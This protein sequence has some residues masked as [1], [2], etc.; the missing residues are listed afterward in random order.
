MRAMTAQVN[1]VC[2]S[3]E[4]VSATIPT[5]A[6][7]PSN[8]V[9][10]ATH[11]P[12]R[13]TSRGGPGRREGS[14]LIRET[15]VLGEFLDATPTNGVLVATVLGESGAGK[16]HLVRWVNATLSKA[17]DA[18]RHVVYLQK[19]ET[20]LKDVV[21][22]LLIGQT[23]PEFDELRRKVSGLGSGMTTDEMEHKLLAELAEALR[24][25]QADNAYAKA[26]VGEHGLRLFFT[27]PL[28]EKHLLRDG[29]FIRRRAEHALRGRSADEGDVPLEFTVAD[30]PLDIEDYNESILE[31]ASATQRLFRQVLARPQMQAEAVRLINANLDVAVMKAASL[32]VGDIGQAFKKIREKLLGDEIILLIE[33]VALIQGVRRDLLDAIVEV[34]VVQGVERYATVRTM[35]AVTPGYYKESLPETFRRRSEATSPLYYV[36]VD[37]D[38]TTADEDDLIDFVGRYLNA[39]RVGKDRLEREAPTV[40]NACLSCRFKSTCHASFGATRDDYGL[41]PYNRSA[42]LR[43][44]RACA[45]K[46]DTHA[47]FNPRKVLSRA[48]RN[49]LTGNASTIEQGTFPPADFLAE[50]SADMGLPRLPTHVRE[51]I[52]EKY[53]GGDAGRLE[54]LVTFWGDV[55]AERISDDALTAFSHPAVPAEV[56]DRTMTD[57]SPSDTPA[58]RGGARPSPTGGTADDLP[59]SL[60]RTL[61][62]IDAWANGRVLPQGIAADLRSIYRDALLARIDWFDTVIKD[63]D[64]ST[65]LRAVPNN[66]RSV[67]IEGATENLAF[68]I[69]PLLRLERSARM[70]VT[71]K[72]LLLL[73]AGYPSR[74]GSALPRVDAV[75]AERVDEAKRRILRELDVADDALAAAAASLI[76]GAI[77]CGVLPSRATDLDLVSACLW[78]DASP[79]PDG[80]SRSPDWLTAYHNYVAARGEAINHLLEGLG[81]AQG[82]QGAVHAIDFRR[83]S[84]ITRKAR[85]LANGD[86]DPVVPDWCRDADQ[87]LRALTRLGARQIAH[88]QALVDR[89]RLHVP[90]GSSYLDTVDAIVAAVRDGQAQGLVRV[91]NLQVL[92]S[93][94]QAAR[95]LDQRSVADVERVIAATA[96]ASGGDLA[97]AVGAVIGGDLQAIADYLEYSAGWV[98]AGIAQAENSGGTVADVDALIDDAIAVWLKVVG[99]DDTSE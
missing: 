68:G 60:Q 56:Y 49:V 85:E 16:S 51:A 10:L 4:V 77:A 21:E 20:S 39:A 91:P 55:G 98:T 8:E 44:I 22:A 50:E 78:R 14:Q 27:D 53:D 15:E 96:G 88:W 1:F 11:A 19:T 63:P 18:K 2:W 35:M 67:S 73:K 83:F 90:E 37:L 59:R 46:A 31:A 25:A 76:R 52:E 36:D 62:E 6:A 13:I 7:T 42:V 45:E 93:K 87:K 54:A 38:S 79:R 47:F 12:L 66:A 30:L 57:D 32:A 75:V 48:V 81:A 33:D 26:L 24:T 70:A 80:A 95:T 86:S 58:D 74:A 3:P 40:A 69:E 92:E 84:A 99:E 5:E 17:P 28:F 72:G 82:T 97:G 71:F 41:Y 94:N 43:A 23:D 29:S 9:L 61:D 34:S 65:L 89:V 64:T